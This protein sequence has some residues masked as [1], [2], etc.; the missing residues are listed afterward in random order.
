M[1]GGN[2]N[3]EQ[4]YKGLVAGVIVLAVVTGILIIATTCV[5]MEKPSKKEEIELKKQNEAE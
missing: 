2:D 4:K 3:E 5:C 1:T